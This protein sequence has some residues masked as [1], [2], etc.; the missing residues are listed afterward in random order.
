MTTTQHQHLTVERHHCGA[1][2]ITALLSDPCGAYYKT[3]RYEGYTKSQSVAR[4]L[5][6]YG[7]LITEDTY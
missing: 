5:E 7:N 1:W 2:I 4:Y 6:Q 3:M